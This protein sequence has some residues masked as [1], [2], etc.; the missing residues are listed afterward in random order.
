VDD[1]EGGVGAKG[2]SHGLAL[3]LSETSVLQVREE[4]YD[5]LLTLCEFH[6]LL[7]SKNIRYVVPVY[8]CIYIYIYSHTFIYI[9]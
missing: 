3:V 2:E 7:T 6:P 4:A 5:L 9:Y 8:V 1:Q